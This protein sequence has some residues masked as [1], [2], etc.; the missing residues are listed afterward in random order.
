[1]RKLTL[2]AALLAATAAQAGYY[3]HLQRPQQIQPQQQDMIYQQR[4]QQLEIEEQ[5]RQMEIQRSQMQSLKGW[6]GWRH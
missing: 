5:R 6:Q 3:D 2:I 1:M 4:Q